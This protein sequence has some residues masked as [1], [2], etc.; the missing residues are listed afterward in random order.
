MNKVTVIDIR[1]KKEMPIKDEKK[2]IHF[3]SFYCF[4]V[5]LTFLVSGKKNAV[6]V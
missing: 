2:G 1:K 5:F 6:K 4:K 3:Y